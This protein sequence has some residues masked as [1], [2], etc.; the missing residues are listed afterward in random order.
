MS[1]KIKSI[2]FDLFVIIMLCGAAYG[3]YKNAGNA[4]SV[5]KVLRSNEELYAGT[6]RV[7]SFDE[8]TLVVNDAYDN[9]ARTLMGD[10]FELKH[11]L[12]GT[13]VHYV[14]TQSGSLFITNTYIDRV[15]LYPAVC[16]AVFLFLFLVLVFKHSIKEED[17][18]E[19]DYY[20]DGDWTE[21]DFEDLQDMDNVEWAKEVSWKVKKGKKIKESKFT[22]V[23]SR[24]KDDGI[25]V[26]G[27]VVAD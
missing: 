9:V 4:V 13:T 8:H 22:I 2:M 3:I 7:E 12:L 27:S 14:Y 26:G 15:L 11:M 21:E 10:P 24:E 6:G 1:G 20:L 25:S 18:T 19:D 17:I 16:L 23:K 5:F